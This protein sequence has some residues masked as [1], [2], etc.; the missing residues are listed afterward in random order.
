MNSGTEGN[1]V[2]A[3]EKLGDSK[4]E[5]KSKPYIMAATATDFKKDTCNVI[6]LKRGKTQSSPVFSFF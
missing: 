6:A 2:D 5:K 3:S 4:C 1:G